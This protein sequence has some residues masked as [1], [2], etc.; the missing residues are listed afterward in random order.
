MSNVAPV[1]ATVSRSDTPTTLLC[2][3]CSSAPEPTMILSER[4]TTS[5]GS[6]SSGSNS[7]PY[8]TMLFVDTRFSCVTVAFDMDPVKKESMLPMVETY[9][10]HR[11]VL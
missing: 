2:T 4:P 10:A 8:G 1:P 5:E 3:D 6:A 11:V 7:I 9:H